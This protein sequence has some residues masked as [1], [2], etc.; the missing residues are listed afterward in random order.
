M[1]GWSESAAVR[2]AAAWLA[3]SLVAFGVTFAIS[4]AGADGPAEAIEPAA[5]AAETAVVL[6]TEGDTEPVPQLRS[7]PSLA[8]LL[9]PPRKR[10]APRP[11]APAP[12]PE[13]PA[14]TPS[15]EPEP[16]PN[17]SPPPSS[18][19]PA[20]QPT[21]QPTPP[22]QTFDSVGEDFDSPG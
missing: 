8:P 22:A 13:P 12:R 18:P 10:P 9:P 14:S 6:E 5:P 3:V 2:A 21:A 16:A 20:P 4:A 19:Q 7:A 17:Y 1:R 11:A 15:P